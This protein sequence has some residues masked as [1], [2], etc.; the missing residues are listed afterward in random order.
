MRWW[1]GKRIMKHL[2]RT[3]YSIHL[4]VKRY[5]KYAEQSTWVHKALTGT[6]LHKGV[7]W[8]IGLLPYTTDYSH[9]IQ[10]STWACRPSQGTAFSAVTQLKC[11]DCYPWRCHLFCFTD[12]FDPPLRCKTQCPFT[13]F[14]LQGA[15]NIADYID[16]S[17]EISTC[18]Q[19]NSQCCQAVKSN[20]LFPAPY[21][22]I[23]YNVK[24]FLWM[25][26]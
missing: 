4:Q 19:T 8:C 14:L 16:D 26:S 20:D 1:G 15:K 10:C 2:S 11:D 7:T 24:S 18:A 9:R 3:I 17:E 25:H 5:I 21:L 13:C 23:F 22:V 12:H 6:V